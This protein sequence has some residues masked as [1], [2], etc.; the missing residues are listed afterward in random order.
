VTRV[1]RDE[2]LREAERAG[3]P[4]LPVF[5]QGLVHGRTGWQEAVRT[6]PAH[7]LCRLHD[8]LKEL[9][10]HS[11]VNPWLN[12]NFATV[13]RDTE[14][15][16]ITARQPADDRD[17]VEEATPSPE[18]REA[19]ARAVADF[20]AEFHLLV[21]P[22]V[23]WTWYRRGD[24]PAGAAGYHVRFSDDECGIGISVSQ[25]SEQVYRTTI[26]ELFHSVDDIIRGGDREARA[27]RVEAAFAEDARRFS[28][29]RC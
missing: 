18:Q 8:A 10:S 29:N 3:Y 5:G 27:E 17:W 16:G 11:R 4:T 25:D 1:T 19:W 13:T 21:R 6:H 20:A 7:V 28:E 22:R 26:H 24:G 2:V 15:E 9:T 14:P 12:P 23:R